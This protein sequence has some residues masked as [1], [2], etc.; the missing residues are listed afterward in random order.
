MTIIS[1]VLVVIALYIILNYQS[2]IPTKRLLVL[3][4]AIGVFSSITHLY[5]IK[6][7]STV[8]LG[9]YVFYSVFYTS[10]FMSAYIMAGR[11]ELPIF[12]GKA[13]KLKQVFISIIIGIFIAIILILLKNI[14]MGNQLFKW[15]GLIDSFKN[16]GYHF[17]YGFINSVQAGITE[18]ILFRFCLITLTVFLLNKSKLTQRHKLCIAILI[19]SVVFALVPMHHFLLTFIVGLILAY[20]YLKLG[21]IP[22]IIIHFL[23]DAIQ[24]YVYLLS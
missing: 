5:I 3:S 20:S 14:R 24:F 22:V 17:W 23:V 21:L 8:A 11:T 19:S 12:W 13:S 6:T 7:V 1:L 4:A 2:Q 9:W 15:Q 18:E 10:I 16:T